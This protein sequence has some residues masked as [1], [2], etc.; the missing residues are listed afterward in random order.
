M[1][2]PPIGSLWL[3][4][5][6]S[7]T[8]YVVEIDGGDQIKGVVYVRRI[9]DWPQNVPLA[10]WDAREKVRLYREDECVPRQVA[11]E[12]VRAMPTARTK[13]ENKRVLEAK[14]AYRRA[15]GEDK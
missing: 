12:L 9:G 1:T 2:H 5:G 6:I 4:T 10:M 3:V 14:A 8:T 11:E 13:A 7:G 15:I